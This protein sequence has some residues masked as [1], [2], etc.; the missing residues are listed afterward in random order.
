MIN[1][2]VQ[3]CSTPPWGG[4]KLDVVN[5]KNIQVSLVLTHSTSYDEI[6]AERVKKILARRIAACLGTRVKKTSI[7]KK[8]AESRKSQNRP[9]Q[10]KRQAGRLKPKKE[11]RQRE[12]SYAKGRERTV[13]KRHPQRLMQPTEFHPQYPY[14]LGP[15]ARANGPPR[16]LF[17]P[18]ER[19]R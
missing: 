2:G 6:S 18:Q 14:F 10:I 11:D 7:K 3:W 8:T 12:G 13:M 4:W 16:G 1:L 5:L 17:Y 15:N 9:S 19:R